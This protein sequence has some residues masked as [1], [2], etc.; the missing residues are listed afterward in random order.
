MTGMISKDCA[1]FWD[2]LEVMV[3]YLAVFAAS[4]FFFLLVGDKFTIPPVVFL[5]NMGDSIC[6][7]EASLLVCINLWE[8]SIG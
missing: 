5:G 3:A 6:I 8:D 7:R 4:S 2:V 1:Y